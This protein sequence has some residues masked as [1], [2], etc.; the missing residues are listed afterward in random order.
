M[1]SFKSFDDLFPPGALNGILSDQD[2]EATEQDTDNRQSIIPEG[3]KIWRISE[4]LANINDLL[5]MEFGKVWVQGEVSGLSIPSSGHHYFTLKEDTACVRSVMFKNQV[6]Q[7]GF[8]LSEG[9]MVICT[10]RL[11]VYGARGDLQLIAD[12]IE[13]WGEGR[14]RIALEELKKR[15]AAQ[16]LF[17]SDRKRPLPEYPDN[18]FVISS[19]TGAA[20]RD[21][22]K[23]AE[24]R[25]PCSSIIICPSSVQGEAAVGELIAALEMAESQAGTNDIIVLARGGGSLEDLWAFNSEQLVRKICSCNIPVVS[26][27]GH[28]VDFTLCD[29]AADV[30]AATPTAA[31]HVVFPARSELLNTVSSLGMRLF[32]AM[33]HAILLNSQRLVQLRR[34]LKDPGRRI[35]ENRLKL[36]ELDNRLKYAFQSNIR[37]FFERNRLLYQ[38]LL[39]SS[40]HGLIRRYKQNILSDSVRLRHGISSI[41]QAKKARFATASGQLDAVSPLSCLNR[42]YCLVYEEKTGNLVKN[43]TAIDKGDRLRIFPATGEIVCEVLAKDEN[44]SLFKKG[45]GNH[46]N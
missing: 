18:I 16:G 20:V 7:L 6:R 17:D 35:I 39:G 46:E 27:V 25:F 32:R 24:E 43:A 40:P 29:L 19:P 28:E 8:R 11:N 5:A 12:S 2:L 41:I 13:P 45:R 1:S 30:R 26:D 36:D 21:F 15:L 22:I 3:Q 10:G 44:K 4:L 9:Q 42:G 37:N 34:Q 14:L 23:T 33:Q 38:K 31:A